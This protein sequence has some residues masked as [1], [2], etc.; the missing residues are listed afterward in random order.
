VLVFGD[1]FSTDSGR[2][3]KLEPRWRGPLTVMSYDNITQN[4]TVKMDA[5][6][7]RRR[8]AVFPSSVVKPYK[9]NDSDRFP[10]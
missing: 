7:Y 3:K 2:S 8:E 1:M 9:E 4:Y 5:R 6:M 10:G